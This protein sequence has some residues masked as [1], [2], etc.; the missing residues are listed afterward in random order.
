MGISR[1]KRAAVPVGLAVAILSGCGSTSGTLARPS[2]TATPV[3]VDAASVIATAQAAFPQAPNGFSFSDCAFAGSPANCPI[4]A[5][6]RERLTVANITLCG[7]TQPSPNRVIRPEVQGTRGIGHVQLYGRRLKLDLVMIPVGP[8][9]LVD[10]VQLTGGGLETSIYAAPVEMPAPPALD[11][12]SPQHPVPPSIRTI[13]APLYSQI[14]NLDCETAALQMGLATFGHRFTQT[15]LFA[16]E[17]PDTRPAMA[18]PNNTVREWGDPFI[19]FVGDV[20]GLETNLTGYGVYYPV[21]LEIVRTHGMPD[22]VGADGVAPPS[23]YHA[24]AAGHPVQVWINTSFVRSPQGTWTAWD[25]RAIP[26]TLHE[27]SVLLTGVS[28]NSVQVNDPLHGTQYWVGKATF[29]TSWNYF[30]NQ[31]VIFQ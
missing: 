19:D 18:G 29:E 9:L 27:H 8:R 15:E 16:L 28:Q 1:V 6:L 5:R 26:Y 23:V 12:G 10:D 2:P 14:M 3:A 22:A 7:C 17:V 30:G 21:I 4:T 20:N 25:G 31:A 13:D 24:I 11:V